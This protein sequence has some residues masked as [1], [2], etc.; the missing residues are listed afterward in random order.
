MQILSSS[1]HVPEAANVVRVE[2]VP[3][4]MD[5]SV[6]SPAITN[7]AVQHSSFEF[8]N[9][10]WDAAALALALGGEGIHDREFTL[11]VTVDLGQLD[12]TASVV[13]LRFEDQPEAHMTAC[14]SGEPFEV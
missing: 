1:G 13:Q 8:H 3:D 9:R 10:G 14:Y 2:H 6:P 12:E 7:V 5:Q 11:E 4:A